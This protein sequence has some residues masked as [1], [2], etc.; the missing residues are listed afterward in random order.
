MHGWVTRSVHVLLSH[1]LLWSTIGINS[2]IWPHTCKAKWLNWP[3]PWDAIFS[4]WA[5]WHALR[6]GSGLQ[7]VLVNGISHQQILHAVTLVCFCITSN[8]HLLQW[9]PLRA[10]HL[11]HLQSHTKQGSLNDKGISSSGRVS[12]PGRPWW[13]LN[14]AERRGC[15]FGITGQSSSTK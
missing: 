15:Q 5:A 11:H 12:M 3:S 14:M 2:L 9:C 1:K 6:E 13:V 10:W 7:V 8:G 4:T